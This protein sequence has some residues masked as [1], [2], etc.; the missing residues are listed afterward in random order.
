[1]T[2]YNSGIPN[3][4]FYLAAIAPG[5]HAWE[6]AG[7]IWYESLRSPQVRP[8]ATFRSFAAVTSHQASILFGAAERKAVVEAWHDVGIA[9]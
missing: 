1:L 7:R 8:N 9:V 4:A 6:R 2:S 3:K 5:G